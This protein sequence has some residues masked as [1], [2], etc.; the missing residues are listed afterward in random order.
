MVYTLVQTSVLSLFGK[1]ARPA[2]ELKT[3]APDHDADK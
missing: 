3:K 1:E 2:I